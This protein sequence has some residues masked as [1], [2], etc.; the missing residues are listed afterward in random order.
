[1]TLQLVSSAQLKCSLPIPLCQ[2]ETFNGPPIHTSAG[3]PVYWV[4]Y[5]E[6]VGLQTR[7]F[8]QLLDE[9]VGYKGFALEVKEAETAGN[10]L[11]T[12]AWFS[13]LEGAN[14]I[15]RMLGELVDGARR[16]GRSLHFLSEKVQG[17]VDS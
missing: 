4:N 7:N 11:I 14:Q 8:D 3:R 10:S 17:A 9:S 1:M 13:D 5:P 6:L 16:T 12:L 2:R 15:A